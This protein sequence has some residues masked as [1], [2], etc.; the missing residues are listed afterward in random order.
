MRIDALNTNVFMIALLCATVANAE[1]ELPHV[2]VDGQPA[3]ASEVNQNFEAL[4]QRQNQV[5]TTAN[6]N[7]ARLD[8]RDI[9]AD[10]LGT[11]NVSEPELLP[12]SGRYRT[13][14]TLEDKEAITHL[15][16]HPLTGNLN[17][18]YL[19]RGEMNAKSDSIYF[20]GDGSTLNELYFNEK[21]TTFELNLEWGYRGQTGDDT[22]LLILRNLVGN[23][24][25]V[26]VTIP[27]FP[28][29][30][31]LESGYYNLSP[32]LTVS[33][34][35]DD[36][37]D[38]YANGRFPPVD[39]EALL[40][41][42]YI[43]FANIPRLDGRRDDY[44]PYYLTP[45]DSSTNSEIN[46]QSSGY[47]QVSPNYPIY[48]KYQDRSFEVN[49]TDGPQNGYQKEGIFQL[50]EFNRSSFRFEYKYDC[51]KDGVLVSNYSVTGSG[52][53]AFPRD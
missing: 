50:S 7:K 29:A 33:R 20:G 13:T 14:V 43:N 12:D 26:K 41:H 44:I 36:C 37:Y 48:L 40:D 23:Y 53:F 51:S 17:L 28:P 25:T 19:D 27:T 8:A 38:A 24:S 21:V 1:T 11:I 9:E 15:R 30:P 2:F 22:K 34:A 49:F 39:S 31:H 4:N 16:L 47:F 35:E 10:L 5:E 32:E 6:S 52:T 3:K 45:A 42:I 18:A 46:G